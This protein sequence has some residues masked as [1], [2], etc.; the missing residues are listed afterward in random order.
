LSLGSVANSFNQNEYRHRLL[1]LQA[2][3][4]ADCY[5]VVEDGD[6][7]WRL[8]VKGCDWAGVSTTHQ[9]VLGDLVAG[10]S[11]FL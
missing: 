1:I 7:G 4:N 5:K 9:L 8:R 10:I 3:V 6:V 2:R 11:Q